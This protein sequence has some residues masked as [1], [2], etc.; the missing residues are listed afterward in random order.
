MQIE[1]D[2]ADI[3]WMTYAELGQSR[4]I[5]VASAKRLAARRRW[6][7]QP[8]ND[9]TVRIGVPAGA[10][11]PPDTAARTVPRDILVQAVTALEAALDVIRD[12]HTTEVAALT[13]RLDDAEARAKQAQGEAQEAAQALDQIRL[14]DDARKARGRWTRRNIRYPRL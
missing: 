4:G 1:T 8:G 3:A 9:G 2:P 5:S 7:R 6:R 12:S 10:E 14:A 11:E 13:A